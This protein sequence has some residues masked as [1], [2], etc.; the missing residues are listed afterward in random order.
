MVDVGSCLE[1][2][3]VI[4]EAA[5]ASTQAHAYLIGLLMGVGVNYGRERASCRGRV[6]HKAWARGAVDGDIGC[7]WGY[8]GVVVERKETTDVWGEG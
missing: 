4:V 5:V 6:R 1:G 8:I 7:K 2:S 3:G